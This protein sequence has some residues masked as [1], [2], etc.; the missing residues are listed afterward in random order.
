MPGFRWAVGT[1]TGT[2]LQHV[3]IC[4]TP[5]CQMG[6]QLKAT[7]T[8]T[9]DEAKMCLSTC[10]ALCTRLSRTEQDTSA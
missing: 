7:Y 8:C 6:Q 1:G 10:G 4:L 5:L 9:P 3:H 2:E